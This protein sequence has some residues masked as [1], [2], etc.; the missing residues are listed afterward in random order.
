MMKIVFF[1]LLLTI[2]VAVVSSYGLKTKITTPA[3]V[4]MKSSN[5]L[6]IQRS[7]QNENKR[8]RSSFSIAASPSDETEKTGVETK[9]LVALGVFFFAC[10][11]DFFVMHGGQVYL[12]HP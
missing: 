6:T 4:L 11:Y 7:Y 1:V 12:A 5:Y 10:V 3:R 9:Y 2:Y 8:E